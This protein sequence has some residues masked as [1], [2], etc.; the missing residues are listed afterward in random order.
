MKEKLVNLIQHIGL[1]QGDVFSTL[2]FN[3]Y[4]NDLPEF[5]NK[6]SNFK[7]DQLH[8]PKLDNVAINNLLFAN[9]LTILSW[10]KYDLQKKISNLENY[11]ENGDQNSI[12]IKLR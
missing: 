12:Q 5:L 6:K 9:D 3:L 1:K 11:C 8:T 4:T 10:S 7:E 2:L